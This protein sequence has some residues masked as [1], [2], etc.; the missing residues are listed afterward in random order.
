MV[1]KLDNNKLERINSALAEL[2]EEV[3]KDKTTLL[4]QLIC[5]YI[6]D[7]D[8]EDFCDLVLAE[9]VFAKYEASGKKTIKL[10][11]I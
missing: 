10:S 11:D 7:E 8:L 3:Q 5:N 2:A 1:S 9:Y 4:N 6:S